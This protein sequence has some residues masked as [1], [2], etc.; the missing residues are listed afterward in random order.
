MR[1]EL[2]FLD[3]LSIASFV[4][5]LQ[6]LDMNISQDDMAKTAE[7]LDKKLKA[8]VEAIHKHLEEQDKKLDI[9]LGGRNAQDR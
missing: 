7:Q 9:L 6:N 8:E 1:D 4:I 5:A 3:L 2:S